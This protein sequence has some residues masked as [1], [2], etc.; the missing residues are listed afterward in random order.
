MQCRAHINYHVRVTITNTNTIPYLSLGQTCPN[1]KEDPTPETETRF[2][3]S[4]LYV[5]L[6]GGCKLDFS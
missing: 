4:F 1:R 2:S 5:S 6:A 3:L